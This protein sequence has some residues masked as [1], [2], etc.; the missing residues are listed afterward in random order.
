L[1]TSI[2]AL[3]NAPIGVAVHRFILLDE[4]NNRFFWKW[5]PEVRRFHAWVLFIS[6]FMGLSPFLGSWLN[7][8]AWIF[9]FLFNIGIIFFIFRIILIFPGT[10]INVTHIRV[11][12]YWR[13]SRGHFWY[14][15]GV[16][17]FTT[18]P[19]TIVF[20]IFGMKVA[21]YNSYFAFPI[22]TIAGFMLTI[23]LAAL[24]SWLYRKFYQSQSSAVM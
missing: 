19:T 15:V 2:G 3:I 24:A 9:G 7:S 22:L 14:F 17:I 16:S 5:R 23:L 13:A 6:L 4:I 10:A 18:L 21:F 12:N 1:L 11:E 20:G 8:I